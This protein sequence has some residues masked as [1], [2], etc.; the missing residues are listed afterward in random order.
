[1][2]DQNLLILGLGNVLL[3]DEGVGIHIINGLKK[4]LLPDCVI[5]IDG[6]TMGLSLID[7]ISGFQEALVVDA[8]RGGNLPDLRFFSLKEIIS[9][10]EG[11][12]LTLHEVGFNN[13]LKLMDALGMKIPDITI[14]GIRI[15]KISPGIG[16]SN[17]CRTVVSRAVTMIME[18]INE[19]RRK[20]HVR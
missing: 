16:L 10:T 19:Y 15:D 1:M 2:S 7:T 8:V 11:T 17:Q 6:G 14:L 5:I 12:G 13:V 18:K 3:G 20:N 9:E 4:K